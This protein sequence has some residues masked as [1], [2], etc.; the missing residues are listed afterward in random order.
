MRKRGEAAASQ[1]SCAYAWIQYYMYGQCAMVMIVP[2]R[3][4]EMVNNHARCKMYNLSS[5]VK[6]RRLSI[7]E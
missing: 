3:K 2:G 6:I 4:K 5:H 1:N 7:Y